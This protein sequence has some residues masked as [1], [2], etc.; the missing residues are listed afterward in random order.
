M[1]RAG[2]VEGRDEF[3]F[4]VGRECVERGLH[5]FHSQFGFFLLGAQP[6]V[7]LDFEF[8]L[9]QGV[10]GRGEVDSSSSR[11]SRELGRSNSTEQNKKCNTNKCNNT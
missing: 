8:V 9:I 4:K 3:E 5:S 11:Q 10:C 2:G 1:C 7:E 6:N